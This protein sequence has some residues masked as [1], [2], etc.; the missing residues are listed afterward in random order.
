E[1]EKLSSL[2]FSPTSRLLSDALWMAPNNCPDPS[3]ESVTTPMLRNLTRSE[4]SGAES[5]AATVVHVPSEVAYSN[6]VAC[7]LIAEQ[8]V[9]PK[10]AAAAKPAK[11]F[12]RVLMTFTMV[13]LVKIRCARGDVVSAPGALH[14]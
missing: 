5:S 7:G 14:Q 11:T 4:V 8:P 2:I 6:V 3:A 13:L 1:N 10:M 12:R 9:V